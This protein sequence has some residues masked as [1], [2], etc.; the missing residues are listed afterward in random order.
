MTQAEPR[1]PMCAECGHS[2]R[3]YDGPRRT[4]ECFDRG[5]ECRAFI[6]AKPV[7]PNRAR[8]CGQPG[9]NDNVLVWTG[10]RSVGVDRVAFYAMVVEQGGC[11]ICHTL[12][13]TLCVDHDHVTG[14]VLSGC[15]LQRSTSR[16]A[17]GACCD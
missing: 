12:E 16:R 17:T 3:P 2:H 6:E 9:D 5:C 7:P 13:G 15:D 1:P 11:A 4:V 8:H 10:T 14:K